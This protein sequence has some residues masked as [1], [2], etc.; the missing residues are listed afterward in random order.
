MFCSFALIASMLLCSVSFAEVPEEYTHS[1]LQ[2]QVYMPNGSGPFQYYAQN[3][4]IWQRTIYEASRSDSQRVFG[5]GGCN[6]TSL[7]MVVASLVPADR[8]NLLG[9]QAAKGRTFT[10]CSC[11]VNKYFCHQHRKDAAHV[12]STL[13]SGRDF[14]QVLP[15]AIGDF[16]TGNNSFNEL[17]R[18]RSTRSGG[19]GGTS[20]NLFQ[21]IADAYGLSYELTKEFD[22]VLGTLDRGGMAI[23]LCSGNSQIF[24]GSNGHYV[25]LCSYDKEYIYV[26]DPYV[27]DE[28]KRDR[29]GIIESVDVGIKKVKLE[30]ISHTGFGNFALFEPAPQTYYASIPLLADPYGANAAAA[31]A[32]I[33]EGP[34]RPT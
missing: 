14:L 18:V 12:Q 7:A 33:A 17:Y 30:N 16:A 19:N 24:S 32:I 4:P 15:L 20:K 13:V 1:E 3:D 25:V 8:L 34:H 23:A 6:P 21:P 11:S 9:L 22:R 2:R 10:L 26:M 28:Y 31:A 27:R 29:N 5:D